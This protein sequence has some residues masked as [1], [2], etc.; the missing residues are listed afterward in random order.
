MTS[1]IQNGSD[2]PTSIVMI[3]GGLSGTMVAVQLLQQATSP[4]SIYVVERSSEIG[5]GVAYSTPLS[6]HLLN[7]PVNG[8]STVADDPEH[9]LRWLHRNDQ[10]DVNSLSFVS[11]RLFGSYIQD[12]LE[13]AIAQA[14]PD[15]TFEAIA[16]E[17]F[18]ISP[19][20]EG[21]RVYLRGGRV[22]NADRVVLALG[23]P[24]PGHVA[25]A[26]P[27]FYQSDRYIASGWSGRLEAVLEAP[28][29]VLIGAGLTAVDWLVA[30]QERGYSGKIHAISRHGLLP[31]P[32]RLT[33]QYPTDWLDNGFPR[34][35]RGVLQWVRQEVKRAEEAGYDWRSVLDTLR[36]HVQTIWVNL[37]LSEKQRCTRHLRPYWDSHR[38]RIAAQIGQIVADMEASGQLQVHA[39]RLHTCREVGQGVEVVVRPRGQAE[40]ETLTAGVVINCSGPQ[41]NYRTLNEALIQ[42][43]L[44]Q[45][46][47]R[48]DPLALG[49][50]A[51]SDGAVLSAKGVPSSWLYTL[52]PTLRG[53]L[54]E[55]TAVTEIRDQAIALAKSFVLPQQAVVPSS[56]HSL[57][58]R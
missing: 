38:H 57:T 31:Q 54:W 20:N 1:S 32:H 8:V 46:L 49:I 51:Y 37:P 43:L 19:W 14:K 27:E 25:I 10:T 52:G 18:R 28:S 26:N 4:L 33:P 34:T 13:E 9:F 11:R 36:F 50:E 21:A 15:V 47:I 3:G 12:V 39:A 42:S 22:L 45:D 16:D 24:A 30:L 23:N 35:A 6:C 29:I 56:N 17:A 44:V 48:L 7:V 55:T 2:R 5:R 58:A 53:Q 41:F 40:F